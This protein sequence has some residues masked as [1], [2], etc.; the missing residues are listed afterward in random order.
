MQDRVKEF[1]QIRK[2]SV[3]SE[4]GMV[5][6]QHHLASDVG[7]AVLRQGGNAIDAAM[8]AGLAIGTVEPWMSGLG[9]GGYT[10]IYLAKENKVHLVEYGMRAPFAAQAADYP[11]AAGGENSADSFNWPKVTG[12]TNIHGPLAV[13]VPGYI[14]GVSMALA[15]FGTMN[16]QQV[17]EPACQLAEWGLPIDWFSA[18]K[19]NSFARGLA[20]YP[21]TQRVYLADGLPPTPQIDGSI[22]TLPLGELARTYRRL[23]AHGP[24]DFYNGAL[25]QDLVTDLTAA[26]SRITLADL[27]AY[28]AKLSA[29]TTTN[30]RGATVHTAGPM[31]AGP[32]LI[33]ALTLLQ[34]KLRDL[35]QAPDLDTF[36]AYADALLEAY[37]YRLTNLGEGD[38]PD[39]AIPTNTTHI[40]VADKDGNVVS[41][42]QTI[43]SAFGSRV[44]LPHT[45]VLMNNGMM[46]FDPRPGRPNSVV[47]G[48]HPLCNMC[49]V[50]VQQA[51]G[52]LFAAGACGGRK[53]FPAVFQLI[54]SMVDFGMTVDAAAHQ[55]RLDVS[56]TD[57]VTIMASLP[58]SIIQGLVDH[59]PE[60]LVRINGVSPNLFA[61]PQIIKR[62]QDGTMEGGCFIPSPHA[63]VSLP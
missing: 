12:D 10:L 48:R 30:Y 9:G 51:D 11:L 7:A 4:A 23:Q 15:K 20:A 24:D 34:D 53:I 42:T 40:C 2:S 14:K 47:G 26:G 43:M 56:G 45:G 29:T 22:A 63:K 49:P 1:W 46:W 61:L 52:S 18:A 36:K 39:K 60:T 55:G 17:I 6:S 41:H 25:A 33:H 37:D 16:W 5:A 19:I 21:E 31:T 35:P 58:D 32:S 8:A 57:L 54:S 50:I 13:A 3:L 38:G 62:R 27:S 28:A 59:Y 44:M